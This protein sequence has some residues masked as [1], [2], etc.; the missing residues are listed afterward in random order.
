MRALLDLMRGNEAAVLAMSA[1]CRNLLGE[2]FKHLKILD[3]RHGERELMKSVAA[4]LSKLSQPLVKPS[5][6]NPRP[7][8]INLTSSMRKPRPST[9]HSPP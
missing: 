2:A 7:E 4:E 9:L 5:T 3:L 1:P 8:I 6:R